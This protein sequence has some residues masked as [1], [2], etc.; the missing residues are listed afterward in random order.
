MRP[1]WHG[2]GTPHDEVLLRWL[3]VW[4]AL[5]PFVWLRL[6]VTLIPVIAE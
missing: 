4:G 6:L 5:I 3:M 1:K 2:I